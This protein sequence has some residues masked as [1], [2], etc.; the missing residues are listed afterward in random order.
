MK[1]M[2]QRDLL[3]HIWYLLVA[4]QH[5]IVIIKIMYSPVI[6]GPRQS[7]QTKKIDAV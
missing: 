2:I 7:D 4:K 3:S 6:A 1:F 5:E